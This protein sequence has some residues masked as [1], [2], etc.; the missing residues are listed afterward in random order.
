M[1][2]YVQFPVWRSR[3]DEETRQIEPC[4]TRNALQVWGEHTQ[5]RQPPDAR[6][7]SSLLEGIQ[8]DQKRRQKPRTC[9]GGSSR[10]LVIGLRGK[11]DNSAM[12]GTL[13]RCGGGLDALTIIKPNVIDGAEFEAALLRSYLRP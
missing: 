7:H 2:M 4:E 6:S 3:G 13:V 10:A 11:T 8:L 1:V 9:V 5:Q 12:T